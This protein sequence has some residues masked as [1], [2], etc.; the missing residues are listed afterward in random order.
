MFGF[1]F[2][3]PLV[4]AWMQAQAAIAPLTCHFLGDSF[5]MSAAI[6]A[7]AQTNWVG[8]YR[9]VT[10]DGVD[11][12]TLT[13]QATRYLASSATVK[14]KTLVILDGGLDTDA[15]TSIAAIDAIVAAAGHGRWLYVEPS[16]GVLVTGSP[17]RIVWDAM[18]AAIRAHV[19]E[20]HFVPTLALALTLGDG[21]AND[22][23]D[24]AN[25]IWPRSLR[26]DSIHPTDA[27]W[28]SV[29]G[30]QLVA[31]LATLGW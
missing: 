8:Q 31:K 7:F 23:A 28:G 9:V 11:G 12:S 5:V 13:Q 20:S 29:I 10:T 16:P 6:Q 27:A 19:G 4:A 30:S 24:I 25:G 2:S 17:E 18:V 1:G 15:A 3:I 26:S 21:S 22:L 14:A